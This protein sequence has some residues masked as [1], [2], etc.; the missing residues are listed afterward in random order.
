MSRAR[1]SSIFFVSKIW[2]KL[3]RVSYIMIVSPLTCKIF[4][5]PRTL[6]R[7]WIGSAR[8][9]LG[10]NNLVLTTGPL[11]PRLDQN[12]ALT[13]S[14]FSWGFHFWTAFCLIGNHYH[15]SKQRRNV[16]KWRASTTNVW[17]FSRVASRCRGLQTSLVAALSISSGTGKV[18]SARPKFFYGSF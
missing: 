6:I 14:I 16:C 8:S 1:S 2:P 11:W 10:A 7:K 13:V 3:L 17:D 18:V 4:D 5:L 9:M 12:Q 15:I